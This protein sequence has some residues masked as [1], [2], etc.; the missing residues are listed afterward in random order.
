ML[1][2][3]SNFPSVRQ[4][5]AFKVLCK[6]A[7]QTL[8]GFPKHSSMLPTSKDPSWEITRWDGHHVNLQNACTC[9]QTSVAQASQSTWPTMQ[10]RDA[11]SLSVIEAA[12]STLG[13]AALWQTFYSQEYTQWRQHAVTKL[14][15]KWCSYLSLSSIQSLLD[16]YMAGNTVVL[17]T[18]TSLGTREHCTMLRCHN[19]WE[20]T[21]WEECLSPLLFYGT[22]AIFVVNCRLTYCYISHDYT[23]THSSERTHGK[24]WCFHPLRYIIAL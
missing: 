21:G 1:F 16:F 3:L 11:V 8:C 5:C 7:L 18:P 10:Q 4:L 6:L 17:F 2:S 9:I 14:I 22:T 12:T 20:A 15:E 19:G 24:P 13:C 23:Y